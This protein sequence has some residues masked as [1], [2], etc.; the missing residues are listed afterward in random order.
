[1]GSLRVVQRARRI[2]RGARFAVDLE[3]RIAELQTAIGALAS[4]MEDLAGGSDHTGSHAGEAGGGSGEHAGESAAGAGDWFSNHFDQA[5]MEVLSFLAGESIRIEGRDVADVGCGDGII[6]LG[7]VTHGCPRSFVGYD[8]VPTD[9]DGLRAAARRAGVCTDLPPNLTFEVCEPDRLPATDAAF[10][11]V[12]SW[13]AFEHV[14]DLDAVAREVRRVLRPDGALF[15]QLWPFYASEYGSHLDDWFPDGNPWLNGGFH[16]LT[17]SDAEIEAELA[18]RV[19]DERALT[20]KLGDFRALNRTT[21]DGLQDALIA[22][23]FD[24]RAVKLLHHTVH[25]PAGL[26]GRHRLTDLAIAGAE[27]VAIPVRDRTDRTT[28][29]SKG[30]EVGDTRA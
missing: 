10:D 19:T 4:R 29:T 1:M 27:L 30:A 25:L 15:V 6:D 16:H 8:I 12:V 26:A 3:P 21:L 28:A 7:L 24:I 11:V 14:A 20:R 18:A 17:R 22:G 5:A 2:A 23:G 13:S 9:V